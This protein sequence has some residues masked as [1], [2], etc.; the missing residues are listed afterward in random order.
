[1]AYIGY[2]NWITVKNVEELTSNDA[3]KAATYKGEVFR[4]DTSV[5]TGIVQDDIIYFRDED[6]TSIWHAGTSADYYFVHKDNVV[7]YEH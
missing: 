2:G 4:L 1:M 5:V 6:V 3:S 7:L